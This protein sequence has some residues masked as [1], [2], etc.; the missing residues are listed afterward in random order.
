MTDPGPIEIALVAALVAIASYVGVK[1]FKGANRFAG[2]IGRKIRNWFMGMFAEAASAAVA[3]DLAH[4]GHRLGTSVDELR[5]ANTTEHRADQARLGAV[6]IRLDAVEA[7]MASLESR[8]PGRLP[9]IRTRITDIE[10]TED[11]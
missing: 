4:L 3:P 9:N 1:L 10:T 6:E 7:R 2:W 5:I 8:L 11:T